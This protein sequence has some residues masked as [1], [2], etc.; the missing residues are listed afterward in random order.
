VRTGRAACGGLTIAVSDT[1]IGLSQEEIAEALK[2]FRQVDN[3]HSRK[4]QGTGLGL[5]LAKAPT[6]LHGGR[7]EIASEPDRGTTASVHLPAERVVAPCVQARGSKQDYSR[8][9]A[10]RAHVVRSTSRDR[11]SRLLVARGITRSTRRQGSRRMTTDPNRGG[12]SA[13]GMAGPDDATESDGRR[14]TTPELCRIEISAPGLSITRSLPIRQLP[15]LLDLLLRFGGSERP[16]ATVPR[17]M[18][19][20]PEHRDGALD[21]DHGT[22]AGEAEAWR[23]RLVAYYRAKR[24][25]TNPEK[26]AVLARFLELEERRTVFDRADIR[27][28]FAA[29]GVALPRNFSR[30]LATALRRGYLVPLS[31]GRT[32]QVG[33]RYRPLIDRDGPTLL[34]R[35][36]P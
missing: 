3:R 33:S 18:A 9:V 12:W 25:A 14:P 36:E 13:C 29:A 4:Y 8:F 7:L 5:P 20:A 6:E 1:G 17:R 23:H 16:A 19:A 22:E 28:R 2:P 31:D 24:P 21:P 15:E 32:Y 10:A 35:S 34:P 11:P 27:R 26:I 30:D